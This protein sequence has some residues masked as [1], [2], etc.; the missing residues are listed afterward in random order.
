MN[1]A[2]YSLSDRIDQ[3]KALDLG[4]DSILKR[5]RMEGIMKDIK[6]EYGNRNIT[7]FEMRVLINEIQDTPTKPLNLKHPFFNEIKSESFSG[8]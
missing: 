5:I 7:I 3:A 8:L 6:M 2:Y 1:K 4:P